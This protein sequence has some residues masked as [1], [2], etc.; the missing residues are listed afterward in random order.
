MLALLAVLVAAAV[1]G[2]GRANGVTDSPSTDPC[3]FTYDGVSMYD[4]NVL[5]RD[6][7][8][9]MLD[10]ESKNSKYCRWGLLFSAGDCCHVLAPSHVLFMFRF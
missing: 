3:I 5:T 9:V 8:Y 7:D 4:M 6:R 2:Q 10:E 1:S